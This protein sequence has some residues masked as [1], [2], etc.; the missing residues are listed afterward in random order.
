MPRYIVLIDTPHCDSAQELLT[1]LKQVIQMDVM[2]G[3]PDDF[4]LVDAKVKMVT[5]EAKQ[6]TKH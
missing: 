4:T 1:Y 2:A 3:D 5:N 6:P